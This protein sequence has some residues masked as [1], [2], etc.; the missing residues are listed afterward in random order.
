MIGTQFE[1]EDCQLD[2]TIEFTVEVTYFYHQPSH[3]GSR[4][5]C[6]SSGDYYGY[7][8]CEWK[9]VG[10]SAFD[11]DGGEIECGEGEPPY[12]LELTDSQITDMVIESI[13]EEF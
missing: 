11:N 6:D 12:T 4:H 1:F 8:D 9:F 3:K 10:W 13:T 7:T 2:K 5:S